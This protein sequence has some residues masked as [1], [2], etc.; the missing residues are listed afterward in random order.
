LL[1]PRSNAAAPEGL[2]VPM[3]MAALG[4]VWL[5]GLWGFY[6]RVARSGFAFR[7]YV[8]APLGIPLYAAMLWRSWFL[9]NVL[10]QVVWKGRGIKPGVQR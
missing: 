8:W 4:I 3:A 10:R 7:D 2:A 1:T 6:A 5:R 9:H